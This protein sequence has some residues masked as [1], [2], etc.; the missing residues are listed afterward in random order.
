MKNYTKHS[1]ISRR[2]FALLAGTAGSAPLALMGA[3]PLTAQLVAQRIQSELGGDWPSTGTD[4]FKAGDPSTVVKGIATTSMATL[5][6]LKQA[7]KTKANLILT[8]EPTFYGR[9]DAQ[10]RPAPTQGRGPT[11]FGPD[12]PVLK[13]K[14]EFIQKNGL[15]VFRLRDHWQT[16]KEN[17]MLT[18]LAG[19]LGW[20]KRQVKEG[21]ALYEIPSATA[22]NIVAIISE[23]LKLRA[24]LRAVGDRKTTVR[25]VLLQPGAMTT[26][27]MWSRYSEVD[28]IVAGEVREWENTHYAADMFTAGEKRVLVTVGRVVSEEPGMRACADWLKTV[29]K[30]VPA[31]WI[32][33]G[34]PYWRPA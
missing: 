10:P 15:V 32:D 1:N 33:A 2:R 25:R 16:R 22:E 14:Q 17:D 5:D 20:A 27:T 19:A 3:E 30:G 4:G 18:A 24:G 29:V 34:D 6:V 9:Q 26:A 28:M 23:R 11:G 31:S 7:V 8:Y 21:D 13:A 12:D